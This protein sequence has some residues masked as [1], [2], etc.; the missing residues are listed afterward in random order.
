MTNLELIE[1]IKKFNKAK[2]FDLKT[3]I[4][5]MENT[6]KED[7]ELLNILVNFKNE[8]DFAKKLRRGVI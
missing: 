7:H 3:L 6:S 2:P 5:I 1:F 8:K 4:S